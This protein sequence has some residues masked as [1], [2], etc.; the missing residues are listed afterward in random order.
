M[1]C[2][3]CGKDDTEVLESRV[4]DC[5]EGIRRRRQCAKCGKR[6]TTFEKVRDSVLWV[7]K[8]DGRRELFDREKIKRG[9]IRACEKR[10]IS[11]EVVN[12]VVSET[13]RECLGQEKEEIST[14]FIGN[15]VLK[16]LRKI[17]KVAWLRFASVYLEFED[18]TDFE[19]LIDK[20][21]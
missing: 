9:I 8:K 19:K 4:A 18:V 15:T 6:F 11:L 1:K 14:E 7:I 3:F 13:E 2:P 10:P 21:K 20:K 5:G 16:K 17:D 12:E